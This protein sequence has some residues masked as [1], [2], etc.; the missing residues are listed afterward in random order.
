MLLNISSDKLYLYSTDYKD[1]FNNNGLERKFPDILKTI[2]TKFDITQ[3][4]I[5]NGPGSFTT[6]RVT[7]LAFNLLNSLS[8]YKYTF[9]NISKI[10]LYQYLY[11]SGFL[12]QY[13]LIF[14]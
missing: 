11:D 1:I 13:G 10:S 9:L 2:T 3:F 14:I 12:P 6:L 4:V 7:T 5:L 8:N